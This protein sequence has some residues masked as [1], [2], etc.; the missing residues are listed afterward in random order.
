MDMDGV[1][2]RGQNL[3]PGADL[4]IEKLKSGGHKFLVLT[5]SSE[6]TPRDLQH[7]LK[8]AGVDIPEESIYTSALATARFL[9]RQKPK[10]TAFVLGEAGVT[11]ALHEIGYVQ[12]ERNPD[13]VVIG[14]SRSYQFD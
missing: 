3:V 5:N 11:H 4:F 12:T 13:Y 2:V 7:R 8:H 10:G 1:I 14:E 9:D 6:F